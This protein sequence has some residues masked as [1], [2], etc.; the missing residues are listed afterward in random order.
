MP[1]PGGSLLSAPL[2]DSA[3]A[4][5][6]HTPEFKCAANYWFRHLAEFSWPIYPGLIL[7][8][9]LTGMTVGNVSLLQLPLSVS[10]FVIGLL[11]FTRRIPRDGRQPAAFVA[12]VFGILAALWPILLA[13]V[14]Y[15]VFQVNLALAVTLSL[16]LLAVKER[17]RAASLKI[18]LR[19]GMSPRLI[20]LVFGILSFQA[21]LEMTGT[22]KTIPAVA[23]QL[24]LPGVAVI[25]IV[26]FVIGFLTGMVSAYVGLGY[27]LLAGMLYQP[28][29]IPSHIL[30]A[31]VSG[32]IGIM[33]AP[34]HVC[35]VLTNE[36][37]GS[38]L[39]RVYRQLAWPLVLQ[40][41]AGIVLVLLH[42]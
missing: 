37:F 16:L 4:G 15:G 29:V 17:P 40:A 2:V 13:I 35:L 19:H 3:L 31:Y 12:T 24:H 23:E 27:S 33:L 41:L 30:L 26:C 39:Q 34:S 25:I 7:T 21:V 6:G 20:F 28:T 9:G 14:L 36:Y 8:A 1:M 38:E 5:T 32:F 10:M 11:V 18:A 22:I 42:S